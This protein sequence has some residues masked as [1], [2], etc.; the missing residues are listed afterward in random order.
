MLSAHFE[1]NLAVID[2]HDVTRIGPRLSIQSR[3][4]IV[5]NQ[6]KLVTDNNT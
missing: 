4:L 1:S 6:S 2:P 3:S 5:Q